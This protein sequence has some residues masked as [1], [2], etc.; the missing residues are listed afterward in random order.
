[1]SIQLTE[2]HLE[3]AKRGTPVR[4][5]EKETDFVVVRADFFD[6]VQSLFD[7]DAVEDGMLQVH[8]LMAEDDA[9]DPLLESYQRYGRPSA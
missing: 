9:A 6:R 1:M 7:E 3:S 2:E 8:D 4:F 5:R